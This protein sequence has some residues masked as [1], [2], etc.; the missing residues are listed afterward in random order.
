MKWNLVLTAAVLAA[1][2]SVVF[3]PEG[4]AQ[5]SAKQ[6]TL[7][8]IKV[9]GNLEEIRRTAMFSFTFRPATLPVRPAGIRWCTFSMV[10]G[11]TPR[12]IGIR[13]LWVPPRMQQERR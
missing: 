4:K 7:D 11:R 6:G 10:T 1:C 8:K 12:R 3:P 5:N 2:V 13:S 9:Q